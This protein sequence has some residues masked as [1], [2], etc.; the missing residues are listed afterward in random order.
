M[1]VKKIFFPFFQE[2]HNFLLKRWWFRLLIL[3]YIF[4]IIASPFIFANAFVN[5]NTDWCWRYVQHLTN[6]GADFYVWANAKDECL[7][8]HQEIMPYAISLMVAGPILLHFLSQ[9][10]FFKVIVDFI[11]LGRTKR[12]GN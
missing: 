4:A 10:V 5:G 8:I 9:L 2:H 12:S 11:A 3:V 7:L 6:T 1:K